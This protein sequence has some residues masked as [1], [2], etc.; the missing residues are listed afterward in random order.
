M[1][2]DRWVTILSALNFP[3]VIHQCLHVAVLPVTLTLIYIR[4]IR[5]LILVGIGRTILHALLLAFLLNRL[6]LLLQT[7]GCLNVLSLSRHHSRGSGLP[8]I[9]LFVCAW[10]SL[11]L[12]VLLRIEIGHKLVV[13][14]VL[15][16]WLFEISLLPVLF[17][18]VGQLVSVRLDDLVELLWLVA[19]LLILLDHLDL[20]IRLLRLFVCN[21]D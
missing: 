10:F 12:F 20:H 14:H 21:Q 1:L 4:A 6:T 5:W 2:W 8:H 16:A 7:L 17:N 18:D 9:F 19:H 11:C 3:D 15:F 13:V